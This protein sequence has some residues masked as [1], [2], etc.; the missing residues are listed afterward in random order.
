MTGPFEPLYLAKDRHYG[1]PGL[2]RIVRCTVCSLIFL[3]P[4]P[5]DD[6]L[7]ALYPQDYYAYQSTSSGAQRWRDLAKKLFRVR[8]ATRDPLFRAP[9]KMLDVGCGTGWFMRE[10]RDQHGWSVYGVE[11]SE[12]PPSADEKMTD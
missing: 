11:V 10:M 1:I 7:A 4:M 5:C 2:F 6:E 8:T 12:R 9:G 3:N